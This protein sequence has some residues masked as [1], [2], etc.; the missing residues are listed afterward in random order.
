[1]TS[2]SKFSDSISLSRP[3][4]KSATKNLC[5]VV[6][7]FQ[8]RSLLTGNGIITQKFDYGFTAVHRSFGREMLS[9]AESNVT[10][11]YYYHTVLKFFNFYISLGGGTKRGGN[12]RLETTR[13]C[14][15]SQVTVHGHRQQTGIVFWLKWLEIKVNA[16]QC[17]GLWL[18]KL[19]LISERRRMSIP[20]HGEFSA[21]LV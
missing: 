5:N 14:R 12:S 21:H 9:H 7:Y 4:G 16:W 19:I 15:Y 1:M 10:V 6:A 20:L 8:N 11:R 13:V 2:L 3:I 17:L 18:D